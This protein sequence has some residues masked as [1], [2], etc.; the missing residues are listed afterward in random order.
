MC[1]NVF[2]KYTNSGKYVDLQRPL[3]RPPVPF[4]PRLH[5]HSSERGEAPVLSYL[6]TTVLI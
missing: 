1:M 2:S 4:P 3:A 5:Y 6:A